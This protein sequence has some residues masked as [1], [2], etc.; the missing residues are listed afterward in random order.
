MEY[1]EGEWEDGDPLWQAVANVDIAVDDPSHVYIV[2]H[3]WTYKTD[4]CRQQLL[5]VER[6]DEKKNIT[7]ND[8][9]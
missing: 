6:M 4:S 8:S 7:L 1:D 9:H 2:D 5:Q 3:A